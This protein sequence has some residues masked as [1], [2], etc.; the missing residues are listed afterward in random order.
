MGLRRRGRY[1]FYSANAFV[2]V[3]LT[4]A[5]AERISRAVELAEGADQ[6]SNLR[7][8]SRYINVLQMITLSIMSSS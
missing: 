8:F 1:P 7:C 5:E 6:G 3:F 2:T 4:L